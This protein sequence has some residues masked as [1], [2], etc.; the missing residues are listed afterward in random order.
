MTRS[1][2]VVPLLG[3]GLAGSLLLGLSTGA[4][5]IPLENLVAMLTGHSGVEGSY[6]FWQLRLPRVL[7]AA[8]VGATLAVAGALLQGLL[9]NP[10]ADPA[11]VGVSA[12][13]ALGAATIILLSG[14][15]LGAAVGG[16]AMGWI[17]AGAFLGSLVAVFGIHRLASV[18]GTTDIITLLLAGIAI[19]ALVG[20]LLGLA[21]FMADDAQLR[22]L[23]FW[24]LGSL[25]IA[26]WPTL[27]C[28]APLCLLLLLC[29]PACSGGLNALALGEAEAGHLGY[30]VERLKRGI[31]VL[32]AGGV[33]AAVAFTGIIGFVGLVI[34][35][36]VRLWAGPG[37][38][39]LVPASAL[40]GAGLLVLADAASRTLLAP[41]ELPIG[42]LT[43]GIG[44]PCFL[45]MLMR[46]R[47]SMLH[48]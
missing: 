10:L 37:H 9:R 30:R 35:H 46:N 34:P 12:G 1:R 32:V 18:G 3:I 11:L 15:G 14:S 38:R 8:V 48:P 26:S 16:I 21:T 2:A 20:A 17:P 31:L 39:T 36:L 28:I 23:A 45:W 19:N 25:G 40:A 5:P 29:A 24:T 22:S 42:I 33:G 27:A 41:A 7:L 4:V 6:V 47:V 44:A 43:S 13:G